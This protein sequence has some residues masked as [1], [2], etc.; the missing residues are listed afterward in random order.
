MLTID[1]TEDD[2]QS[3]LTKEERERIDADRRMAESEMKRLASQI[4]DWKASHQMA[5]PAR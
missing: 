3:V 1:L 5:R 2:V 4:E